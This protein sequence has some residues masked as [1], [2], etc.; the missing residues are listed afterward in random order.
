MSPAPWLA[1]SGP[2]RPGAGHAGAGRRA[3]R[4]PGRRL[5]AVA[6]GSHAAHRPC[7][8]S[9][10]GRLRRC[11]RLRGAALAYATLG[12]LELAAAAFHGEDF[13]AP[14]MGVA[15]YV[16][17]CASVLAVGLYGAVRSPGSAERP[18]DR[19]SRPP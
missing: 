13:T 3:V 2:L 5:V 1:A 9:I 6:L 8:R 19:G 4:G 11:G 16:A 17:A 18:P 15:V 14:A 10:P 12:A 7:D